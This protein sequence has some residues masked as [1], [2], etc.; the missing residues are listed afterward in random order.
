MAPQFT[1][2][3]TAAIQEAFQ[4]AQTHGHTEVGENHLLR[5]LLVDPEG[6]FS[7]LC[8][9]AG[10]DPDALLKQTEKAL[11]SAPT[12]SGTPQAPQVSAALQ[13]KILLGAWTCQN[14]E[15]ISQRDRSRDPKA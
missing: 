13:H 3:V 11:D 14:V 9:A 6:Y 4:N 10:I 8:Q 12:Y 5:A 7:S 2:A 1:E 15:K